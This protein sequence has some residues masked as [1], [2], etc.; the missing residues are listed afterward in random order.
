MSLALCVH[1]VEKD[2]DVGILDAHWL[3]GQADSVLSLELER[4]H[5]K[6]H[7]VGS[8]MILF[9]LC[10]SPAAKDL[11]RHAAGV[12]LVAVAEAAHHL[13]HE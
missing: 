11:F 12:G 13:G 1:P 6:L 10:D 9:A 4:A 5:A 2:D 7:H 3:G 8:Y